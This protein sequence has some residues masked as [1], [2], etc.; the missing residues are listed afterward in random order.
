MKMLFLALAM[1]AGLSSAADAAIIAVIDDF[2]ANDQFVNQANPTSTVGN[3]TLAITNIVQ[4]SNVFP[5]NVDPYVQVNTEA[6]ALNISNGSR[7]DATVNLTYIIAADADLAFTRMIDIVFSSN[8]N[9]RP[10]DSTVEAFVGGTSLGIQ[11]LIDNDSPFTISFGLSTAQAAIL[12][13]GTT[14]R[15]QFDG[16]P[17][18]DVSVDAIS[19]V[20]EPGMIGLL[21][22]GVLALGV[23]RRRAR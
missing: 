19:A 11:A 10:F 6:S 9:A 4:N 3:R 12:A 21:G 16:S 15:F 20:P 13:A 2:S 23:R 14:L 1:S 18:Y 7:D 22:L 17:D 8:D 5:G